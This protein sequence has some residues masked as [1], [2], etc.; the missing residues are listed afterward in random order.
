MKPK[1]NK[2]ARCMPVGRAEGA[3]ASGS[4]DRT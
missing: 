2:L 1:F 4:P 3:E